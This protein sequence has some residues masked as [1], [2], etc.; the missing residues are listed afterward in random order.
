MLVYCDYIAAKIQE[1]L[2]ALFNNP[3]E[4]TP[5]ITGLHRIV[6]DLNED[7]SFRSSKKTLRCKIAGKQYKIT[8]EE[9]VA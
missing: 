3:E 4:G 7:G 9:D 1:K 8:V 6:W 2:I 5:S